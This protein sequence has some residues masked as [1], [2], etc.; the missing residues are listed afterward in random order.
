MSRAMEEVAALRWTPLGHGQITI[1]SRPS[2]KTLSALKEAT[3]CTSVFSLL[4]ADEDLPTLEHHCAKLA[5][6]W[7]NVQ[8]R[9]AN[10]HSLR[11]ASVLGTIQRGLREAQGRLAAGEALLIHCAGGIHRTGFFTYALL[12][13]QGLSRPA[14]FDAIREM[15]LRTYQSCGRFRFELAEKL[16]ENMLNGTQID[17]SSANNAFQDCLQSEFV[18]E[19]ETPL[20]WIDM[21]LVSDEEI[22]ISVNI[23][24][25]LMTKVIEGPTFTSLIPNFSH[26]ISA[27]WLQTHLK[28]TSFPLPSKSASEAEAELMDFLESSAQP[29]TC[30]LASYYA[31]FD[32][33]VLEE[34]FPRVY[35]YLHYR[36]VD[37]STFAVLS[38]EK[39]PLEEPPITFLRRMQGSLFEKT[40][41][42]VQLERS[43]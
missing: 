8:I 20:L 37:L 9:G 3:P 29:R 33:E 40:P 23:T 12:R 15:R 41:R 14:A 35:A 34:Y 21:S 31:Y 17:I 27:E 43:S 25:G 19:E 32:A 7:I 4:H 18:R 13:L 6:A 30:K 5:L 1:S 38:K 42:E 24:N 26:H 22:A 10:K 2:L 36:V 39:I 28:A 16:V 11:T